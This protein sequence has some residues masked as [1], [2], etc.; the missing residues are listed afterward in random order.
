[1]QNRPSYIAFFDLD[2][3]ILNTNSG[4][5]F[6]HQAYE[7]GYM[8]LPTLLYGY[9]L[10]FLFYLNLIKPE[11]IM[12]LMGNWLQGFSEK[13]I[14]DFSVEVFKK[15]MINA[16]HKEIYAEIE[17][18]KNNNADVVL[19][20]SSIYN[21]CKPIADY[22]KFDNII[23]SMMEVS[24]DIF[25]GKVL[26]EFCYSEIKLKQLKIFCAD[27]NI[28]ISDVYYYGD[29]MADLPVLEVIGNPVCI[30]PDKKL[31]KIAMNRKKI[32]DLKFNWY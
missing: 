4:E 16:I 12:K 21:L 19:L 27:K 18:H 17:F 22:L 10:S 23:C 5:I 2:K 11:T 7:S 32:I 6:I 29:S 9:F 26:G 8:K 13:M 31:R 25:T 20:S 15:A 28:D 24:N 3:T 30:N 14:N 1:M